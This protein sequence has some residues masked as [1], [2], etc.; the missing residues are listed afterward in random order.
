MDHTLQQ[1]WLATGSTEEET[2]ARMIK[3]FIDQVHRGR[4]LSPLLL[5]AEQ[6]A[7][8]FHLEEVIARI[9]AIRKHSLNMR[10][11]AYKELL[12]QL[13]WQ[14]FSYHDAIRLINRFMIAFDL[15]STSNYFRELI[16]D[17]NTRISQPVIQD[18]TLQTIT[19]QDNNDK[20][21]CCVCLDGFGENE[22]LQKCPGC[23]QCTHERCILRW[24]TTKHSC[25]LCR[26]NL[27]QN[28][29]AFTNMTYDMFI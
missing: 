17:I 1:P 11:N 28:P 13:H 12:S 29:E 3:D 21:T 15:E 4:W 8:Y 24:L 20:E 25:P 2:T 27:I 26:H 5:R 7:E 19:L 14:N 9:R 10:R 6:R 16:D 22:T 18:T 23:K